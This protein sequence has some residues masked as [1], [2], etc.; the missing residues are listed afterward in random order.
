MLTIMFHFQSSAQMLVS[1]M[2]VILVST[3]ACLSSDFAFAQPKAERAST[4]AARGPLPGM[5]SLPALLPG[6]RRWQMFTKNP[7]AAVGAVAWSPDSQWLAMATGR[8]VRIYH[9]AGVPEFRRI[10]VGHTDN[11]RSVRYSGDGR[12]IATASLDGTAR[13]WTDEG[14]EVLVYRDH[15]DAVQDVSWHPDGKRLATGSVDGTVRIWSVEGMT[16]AVLSQHEAP[17]NAVAWSSDGKRLASGCENKSIRIWTSDGKVGSEFG[18]HLG[19]IESLAWS[20]DGQQLLSCDHGVEA[21]SGDRTDLAHLK[22]WDIEG[23]PLASLDLVDSPPSHVCWKPDGTQ[24]LAGAAYS[25]RL[26]SPERNESEIRSGPFAPSIPVAW[27]P[28]GEV[29]AAGPTLHRIDGNKVDAM[30]LRKFQIHSVDYA[31]DDDRIAVGCGDD[32]FSIFD[33][34]GKRLHRSAP[35]LKNGNGVYACRWSPDGKTLIAATRRSEVIHKFDIH[36]KSKGASIHVAGFAPRGLNW[37]PDGEYV[38]LGGDQT[39]I[40]LVNVEKGT[41]TLLGRHLHG[42]TQV[43]FSPDGETVCSAGYDSCVR[44]WSL[45]GQPGPVIEVAAA[46]IRGMDWDAEGKLLATGHEDHSIRL[47]NKDGSP[48]AIIGGHGGYVETVDFHPKGQTLASGSWD[49][50]VRI[51]NRDGTPVLVLRGHEGTLGMVQWSHDGR[52]LLSGAADGTV[53]CWDP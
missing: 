7:K 18:G 29:F 45:D 21:I 14:Q 19:A 36:G 34:E 49:H 3:V 37:S 5:I 48:A 38:A 1:R 28:S 51:W 31:P 9:A 32:T 47:W 24:V 27:R 16:L 4:D 53:R 2:L 13:I 39:A 25:V 26:W 23:N 22:V 20:P 52:R 44:F 35:L 50:T 15:E 10:L 12:L 46:Q 30:P 43:Q 6:N 40:G 8:I 17:V 33:G 11:V 42:V 41:V